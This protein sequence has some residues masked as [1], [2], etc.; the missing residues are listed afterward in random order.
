[1]LCLRWSCQQEQEN[2]AD[3]LALSPLEQKREEGGHYFTAAATARRQHNDKIFIL[4][5]FLCSGC[6]GVFLFSCPKF[7][8]CSVLRF[9]RANI[10]RTVKC[11]ADGEV[12]RIGLSELDNLDPKDCFFFK[13]TW[14]VLVLAGA[15]KNGQTASSRQ[16][17]LC[18]GE[19]Q[20]ICTNFLQYT[21]YETQCLLVVCSLVVSE[22]LQYFD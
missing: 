14:E 13:C 20:K 1:M 2:H 15:K 10:C 7:V 16:V 18:Y 21:H 17:I 5:V 11:S 8:E 19:T 22:H 9:K 6:F 3:T 12:F 4:R